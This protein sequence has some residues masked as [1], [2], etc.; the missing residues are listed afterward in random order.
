[1]IMKNLTL[2]ATLSLMLGIVSSR[3]NLIRI[4]VIFSILPLISAIV[5]YLIKNKRYL[6]Y[7][8]LVGSFFI[9]GVASTDYFSVDKL[10]GIYGEEVEF[11]GRVTGVNVS[12][13]HSDYGSFS[14]QCEINKDYRNI[15]SRVILYLEKGV[16][17]ILEWK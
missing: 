12:K 11:T 9:L 3:Y 10:L 5:Y 14:A 16:R 6:L 17:Y 15:D 2:Y 1:M 13:E 4:E 8:A 7:A